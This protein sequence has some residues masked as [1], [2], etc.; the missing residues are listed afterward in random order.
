MTFP[1][2]AR[3]LGPSAV[4]C[5]VAVAAGA[6]QSRTRWRGCSGQEYPSVATE[7]SGP[8]ADRSCTCLGYVDHD[9]DGRCDN[10]A[11]R[12]GYGNLCTHSL[13]AHRPK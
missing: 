12:D 3:R 6:C 1:R 13:A 10:T 5:V 4:L 11:L 2:I 7:H 9:G 8:C